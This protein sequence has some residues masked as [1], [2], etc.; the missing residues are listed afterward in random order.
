MTFKIS[1]RTAARRYAL[2]AV[3]G[4]SAVA[5][6]QENAI[7]E[8]ITVT[9]QKRAENLQDT[10]IAITALTGAQLEQLGRDDLSAIVAQTPTMAY[11][12]A[13]G[14]S[15]IYIRGVGSNL[16]NVGADPSVAIHLDGVY[17]GRSNMGLTQFLDV[18]RVE[19][20]RGPQG[21]LYGRN[22][23]GGA[24]NIISR[25]PGKETA[26]YVSGS[27]GNFDRRE[28]RAAATLANDGPW[29]ARL[30]G[31]WSEDSGY[32][33]D[34]DSRG[35]NEIDDNNLYALR[36]T[37]RYGGDRFT[38]T[39]IG[40]YSEFNNGNTSIRPIDNLGAAQALGALATAN[41]H[42]TRNPVPS[43]NDWQTGGVTLHAR[44]DIGEHL[45]FTSI[46]AYRAWDSDFLFNTDGTEIEVTRTSLVFDTKQYSQ[47][48]QL[49]S[50]HDKFR[51]IV[52]AYYLEEDK[53]GALGLVRLNLATPGTFQI[54]DDND[55]RAFALFG[56]FDFDVTD[57]VSL[58]AGLRYSDESKSDFN[59]QFNI[60]RSASNVQAEIERGLFGNLVYPATPSNTPRNR[61]DF[62]TAT[63]PKVGIQFKAN[64][65]MLFYASWSKGFKSGGYN[66]F[67]PS[68]PVYQPEFI[69][70]LEFG[71]K[72]EWADGRVR[73]NAA[74]FR[75]NYSDLQVS[76]FLNGLTF[77]ANAANSTVTGAEFDLIWKPVDALEINASVAFLDAKYEQ[78]LAIYGLCT[79]Y[80]IQVIAD[81][82]CA[83]ITPSAP[84]P[85]RRVNAAGHR[86]NN[87]PEFKGL[88]SARYEFALS[89]GA[90]FNLFG[91]VSHTGD[92]FFNA[93]NAAVAKQKAYTL[94]DLRAAH[95]NSSGNLEF[96]LFAKNVTDEKYFQ[97]IVQFTST[98]LPPA[99]N[100]LPAPG[101]VITDSLSVGNALGY[102][103]PGR[104]F[105]LEVTYRF[106]A[107]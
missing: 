45:S 76:T 38:A 75:Y 62:W 67:Q 39:L 40:D 70:S 107:K 37:L 15:Q 25:M 89:S 56:Q 83:G 57:R 42:D 80:A 94:V 10:P 64:D 96:A 91:S 19:V 106:G 88:L 54:L 2:L 99:A 32:T 6:A 66:G 72:T 81:A 48:L 22:A 3:T 18:E 104:Q 34:L 17:L 29:S 46:S 73:L 33:D 16:F 60:F 8:E 102:A 23:T 77:T 86:L 52:G 12:E 7:L 82:N 103:A 20:L 28:L 68:N 63:T 58:T 92:I 65:D 78:Y 27:V 93:A 21:T 53:F 49:A 43:F 95:T 87:S 44:W 74:A 98:S 90:K 41:F 71:A 85:A 26:G 36:G 100:A 50:N 30:A 24:I 59:R 97:N 105:G 1:P 5:A 14:E 4:L 13:G 11:S 84:A 47:E 55:G 51:W 61:S 101:A 9:A 31:R 35:S 69:R 79:L